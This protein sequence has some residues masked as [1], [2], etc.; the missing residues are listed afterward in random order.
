MHYI[1]RCVAY[2]LK[3]NKSAR[4]PP[5]LRRP[6]FFEKNDKKGLTGQRRRPITPLPL[7]RNETRKNETLFE[8]KSNC[9]DEGG[10]KK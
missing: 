5:V 8:M 6:R 9:L 1:I 2:L 10:E 7:K 3:S 4:N